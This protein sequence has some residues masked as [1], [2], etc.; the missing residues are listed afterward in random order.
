M[1]R[2]PVSYPSNSPNRRGSVSVSALLSRVADLGPET[3]RTG[4]SG[5]VARRRTLEHL[6]IALTDAADRLRLSGGKMRSPNDRRTLSRLRRAEACVAELL[7]EVERR[8][9]R[10]RAQTLPDAILKLTIYGNL[11]GYSFTA[12]AAGV[13]KVPIDE[14]LFFSVLADLKRLARL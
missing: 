4:L 5:L 9:A 7:D 13:R 6:L 11:Q 3:R 12:K 2:K 14:A 1:A 8:L 10:T